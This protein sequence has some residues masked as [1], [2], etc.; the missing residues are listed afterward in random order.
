MMGMIENEFRLPMCNLQAAN[1]EA[2]AKVLRS[3]G[4]IK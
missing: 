1:R 3:Y 2:L 4:L